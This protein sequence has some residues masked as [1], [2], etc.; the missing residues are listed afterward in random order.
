[1]PGKF[2]QTSHILVRGNLVFKHLA[3]VAVVALIASPARAQNINTIIDYTG[4]GT[5]YVA[6]SNRVTYPLVN[7]SPGTTA[8]GP[9]IAAGNINI[10][11]GLF[12]QE[13]VLGSGDYTI[14]NV[15]GWI[16]F[17]PINYGP[18]STNGQPECYLQSNVTGDNIEPY[19]YEPQADGSWYVQFYIV[20]ADQNPNWVAWDQPYYNGPIPTSW[21]DDPTDHQVH[22][23]CVA[24]GPSTPTPEP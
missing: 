1:M 5:V 17:Q 18:G 12:T 14:P 13:P 2:L 10:V 15:A 24:K 9:T 3:F 8:N 20:L 4:L 23:L 11:P 7:A 6:P 16:T 19:S 22:F 21:L